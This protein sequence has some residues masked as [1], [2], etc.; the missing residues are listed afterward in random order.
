MP[1]SEKNQKNKYKIIC[2]FLALV[3]LCLCVVTVLI[4]KNNKKPY[5]E[6]GYAM[7][8]VMQ[9]TLYGK[10]AETASSE[11]L[12]KVLATESLI[13]YREENSDIS[14]INNSSETTKINERTKEILEICLDV[15]KN[16]NGAFD[17]SILP[18]S[19][20]WDFDS[21]NQK[22]PLKE[23][24]DKCLP[25]VSYENISL[26]NNEVSLLKE[27]TA[28][29]LGACGK[30]AACDDAVSVYKKY[31]LSG[32]VV[33]MGGSIGVF[34]EKPDKKDWLI[35]VRDPNGDVS[36]ILGVLAV[37]EGFI[38]TSGNYEKCFTENGKTYHHILDTKSGYP[39]ENEL[40]SVTV[41]A[42]SGVLSDALSTAC[43]ALGIEESQ[44]LLSKYDA[45]AIFVDKNNNIVLFGD[46][47]FELTNK[48]YN[49]GAQQ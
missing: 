31:G 44:K 9:Q 41:I 37:S 40:V 12:L 35:G 17:I 46:I 5:Y 34:G 28:I 49:L 29:D 14:K 21:E 39:V 42:E 11:A 43:F 24:I 23:T 18:L 6:T 3:I 27:G 33:Y 30:G 13:S 2:A 16:S 48:N 10:N 38:S 32:A 8:S 4:H 22:V 36:D 19:R 20:L 26:K 1:K 25:F 15:A 7:G 47:K 45:S